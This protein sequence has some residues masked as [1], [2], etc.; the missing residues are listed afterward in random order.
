[1]IET[2]FFTFWT[3]LFSNPDD[4]FQKYL[5]GNKKWPPYFVLT[6][7]VFGISYGI[8]RIDAQLIK[9]DLKGNLDEIPFINNWLG[10]WIMAIIGG[11]MGGSI[12]Y[13]IGSWF[14][15]VRLKWSKG[16]GNI[17]KSRFIFL[18]SGVIYGWVI[19]LVT[20]TGMLLNPKPYDPDSDI[21]LWDLS[22]LCI[23]L[24]FVYYSIYVSY[25]GVRSITDADKFRRKIWFL[26]LPVVFYT[27]LYITLFV[28]VFNYIKSLP[29]N[30]SFPDDSPF[31]LCMPSFETGV[32]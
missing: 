6:L 11:V 10:Y 8:D 21:N 26:I 16:T 13:L 24:F 9:N 2:F 22:T 3:K 31:A 4:F 32:N 18:Y 12:L 7:I 23:Q 20:F 5:P 15:N 27:I 14:F 1:M 30:L 19:I 28:L 25:C 17:T 29:D